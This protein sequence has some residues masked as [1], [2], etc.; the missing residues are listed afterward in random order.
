M[1]PGEKKVPPVQI[2]VIERWIAS[3]AATIRPE[4]ERLDPGVQITAE[5]RAHWAFQPLKRPIT[6]AFGASDRV[7]TPVD[8]FVLAEL[9]AQGARTSLPRRIA[10][11]LAAGVVRPDG[12]AAVAN[13]TRRV[14]RRH[15]AE[16]L[17][18][19][20]IACSPRPSTVSVAGGTGSTSRGT[21]IPKGTVMTIPFVLTRTNIETM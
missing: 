8:A 16:C 14:S 15:A 11:A 2:A 10:G 9:F 21:P 4:P 17:R 7:R 13:R 12:A 20:S 3:G 5:E 6:P 1:P 19:H 18:G